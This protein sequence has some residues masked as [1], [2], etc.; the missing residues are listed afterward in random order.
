MKTKKDA[1]EQ[2]YS[3]IKESISSVFENKDDNYEFKGI[4]FGINR[5]ESVAHIIRKY[6][7][8]KEEKWLVYLEFF[9]RVYYNKIELTDTG[10]SFSLKKEA[11]NH[12]HLDP[13]FHRLFEINLSLFLDMQKEINKPNN[14][15][16]VYCCDK[17]VFYT[18]E[19][20][21][22]VILG[23]HKAILKCQK[24]GKRFE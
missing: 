10:E 20:N 22:K 3:K 5:G 24:C 16:T 6:D 1:I 8:E 23:Q 17:E 12:Y 7:N 21:D 18:A 19:S 11:L 9:Y 2:F 14:S 15:K 13:Y 4:D